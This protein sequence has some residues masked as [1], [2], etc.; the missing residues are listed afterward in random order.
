MR[1]LIAMTAVAITYD[2]ASENMPTF[3]D[4]ARFTATLLLVTLFV[5]G[6]R[7]IDGVRK[8]K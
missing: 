2:I 7:Q 1:Y 4:S 6:V 5:M 3:A 8:A